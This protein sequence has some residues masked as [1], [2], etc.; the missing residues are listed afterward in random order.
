[1][2]TI[3]TADILALHHNTPTHTRHEEDASSDNG[4]WSLVTQFSCM[5]VARGVL[6]GTFESACQFQGLDKFSGSD[7]IR[8]EITRL[9]AKNN[10]R[11]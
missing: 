2:M 7:L 6:S 10:D 11:R 5:R 3:Q 8:G 1:M 4:Q 9:K